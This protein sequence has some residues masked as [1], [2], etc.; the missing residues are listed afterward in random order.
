M[1]KTVTANI[2]GFVFNIDEQAYESLQ[3]YLTAIRHQMHSDDASEVMHD[4]EMRIAE[5]FREKLNEYKREVINLTDV[6]DIISVMGEPEAYNTGETGSETKNEEKSQDY[7]STSRQIFR[8]PDDAVLGGICS[9]LGAYMGWD[10]L[11]IRLFFVLLFFGF[12]TGLLLYIILWIIV[13]EAKTASDRLRMR[14]EKINVENIKEKF[15]DIKKDF[16]GNGKET[17][18]KIKKGV[19]Q[20]VDNFSETF[21]TLARVFSIILASMLFIGALAILFILIKMMLQSEIIYLF[22]HNNMY[23]VTYEELETLFFNSPAQANLGYAGFVLLLLSISFGL[24]LAAIRLIFRVKIPLV[25]KIINGTASTLAIIFIMICTMQI[26]FDFSKDNAYSEMIKLNNPSDTLYIE[27][28]EDPYFSENI[29]YSDDILFETIKIDDGK[30]IFGYPELKIKRTNSPEFEMIIEKEAHGSNKR[31]ALSRAENIH[32][33]HQ[34]SGSEL[35][36][37]PYFSTSAKN[38]IRLQ[39]VTVTLYVPKNKYVYMGKKINRIYSPAEEDE[40]DDEN[41]AVPQNTYLK[42]TEDGLIRQ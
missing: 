23:S 19:H 6:N 22:T 26:G 18:R 12:G 14:G 35:K 30:I 9:G 40:D 21:G 24:I 17:G 27:T 36:L 41:D 5:L 4:V 25:F 34:L 39:K 11:I 7:D 3:K 38:K 2:G 31:E 37:A 10:P 32:Y 8:D 33:K 13:P 29:E 1:N 15:K 20:L 28:F 42:M 16:E